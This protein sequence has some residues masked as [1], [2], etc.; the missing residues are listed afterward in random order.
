MVT[1][2]KITEPLLLGEGPH[3]DVASQSLFLVDIDHDTL[4]K[5]IP[6]TNSTKS[7]K[8]G[9]GHVGFIIPVKGK[10][11]HFVVGED[12][13]IV[14]VHWDTVQ[15]K[16]VSKEILAKLPED[17]K[18]I[19]RINDAKC[20]ASGR[21]WLGTMSR[22]ADPGAG[23]F[24]SYTKSG[25]VKNH[26]KNISIS[27][28]IAITTDNEKFYYIDS[29]KKTVDE[30]D[31]NIEGGEIN[32]VRASFDLEKNEVKGVPDGMTMDTDG[33]LWVAVFEGSQVLK[34]NPKEGKVLTSVKFPLAHQIT[35][36]C[37]G[38]ANL[39]ELY[40]TS[41]STNWTEEAAR[42]YPD[43][44]TTYKVT[45]LGVKGLPADEFDLT[46]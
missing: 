10:P 13:N 17:D 11:D 30:F 45:G 40:V 9:S 41:A 5:Y 34:F 24:Y 38:G 32:Y 2:E 6:K 22:N 42:K 4:I 36:V 37:F 21:L 35:S 14:L 23:A 8:L 33:N 46:L 12:L 18:P 39:D 26:L 25:G 7:I 43:T 16:I 44:G 20:D 15:N 31:F 19:N 3:W 27:N 28:G 29:L 1:I